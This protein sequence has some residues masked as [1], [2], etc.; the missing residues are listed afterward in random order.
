MNS[1]TPSSED[2]RLQ[3]LLDLKFS[4]LNLLAAG[5]AH[6]FN[7]LVAGILGCAEIIALD[8][9]EKHPA[10]ES[11]KQIFEA[12]HRARDFIIKLRDLGQRNPPE[13]KSVPLQTIVEEALPLLRT[14]TGAKVRLLTEFSACPPVLADAAQI[15]AVITELCLQCWHGLPERTGEISFKLEKVSVEKQFGLLLPGPQVRLTVRDN[16]PGLE[17]YSLEKIFDPF[18]LRRSNGK[19][20]GLELFLVRETLHAHRGEIAAQSAPGQ[21]LAFQLYFPARPER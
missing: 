14:I 11:L 6:E 5:T 21:G 7:N 20:I 18:H 2:P 8:L 1:L 12:T 4:A 13:L 17:A 3:P 16:G 19:K 9:P 15:Q 10:H